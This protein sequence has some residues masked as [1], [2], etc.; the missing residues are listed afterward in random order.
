ARTPESN[1]ARRKPPDPR[2]VRGLLLA[3]FELSRA[4]RAT[5]LELSRAHRATRTR[6]HAFSMTSRVTL[7]ILALAVGGCGTTG[8]ANDANGGAAEGPQN[9]AVSGSPAS[10]IPQGRP[11]AIEPE[12]G[13]QG[14][15][16]T[17]V[18]PVGDINAHAPPLSEIRHELR[19][20]VI[21]APVTN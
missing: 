8:A 18:T 3:C 13:V 9:G 19:L 6:S 2:E 1:R 14:G 16:V 7:V 12:A 4:Y 17:S 5:C 21:A 20:E 11:Q 15:G 10:S